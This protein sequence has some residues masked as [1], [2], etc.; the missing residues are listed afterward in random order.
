MIIYALASLGLMMKL[1]A[2]WAANLEIHLFIQVAHTR[3]LYQNNVF[4]ILE[5]NKNSY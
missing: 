2:L 1:L 4:N 5:F 3:V